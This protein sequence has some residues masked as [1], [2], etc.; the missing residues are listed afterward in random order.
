VKQNE[1]Y[2]RYKLYSG[3]LTEE[4]SKIPGGIFF[5]DGQ[6][7][8]WEFVIDQDMTY[9]NL[10]IPDGNGGDRWVEVCRGATAPTYLERLDLQLDYALKAKQGLPPTD[11]RQD[12]VVDWVEVLQKTSAV[13]KAPE[14]FAARPVLAGSAAAGGTV[15]CQPNVEGIT[16]IRYY[17]FADGYPL[18]YG[19]SATYTVTPAESGTTL[20]CMVKAVGARDMP[21]AWSNGVEIR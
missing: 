16:D 7:H 9:V 8:T 3:E 19:A 12:F 11:A 6:F 5:W 2:Q 4:K 10:T 18:T 1:S 21:E 15:T 20:R 14:P 17:W 13:E